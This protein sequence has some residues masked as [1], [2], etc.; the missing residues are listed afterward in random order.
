MPF[1]ND[2]A[3]G[4]EARLRREI[5]GEVMFD[6]FS[7]GRYSTDASIYQIEPLGRCCAAR[8]RG[9]RG[10][11][12]D[13]PRRGRAGV[14][15][16]GRHLAMRADGGARACP[17]LQQ[18]HGPGDLGRRRSA[19]RTGRTGGCPRPA[20]PLA[21]AGQIVLSGRPVDGEPSDAGR[22]D[23]QQQLRLALPALRQHGT[24]RSRDRRAARRRHYCLV[25][26]GPGQFR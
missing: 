22:H 23:S 4:L 8:P 2:T 25:W 18:A 11:D 26:R 10:R 13:S 14:A 12:C 24:Q 3:P 15:A 20:Q 7:R 5:R 17:R 21:K 1:D 6:A 19:P 9:C 16:G